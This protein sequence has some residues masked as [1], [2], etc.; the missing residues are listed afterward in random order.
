MNLVSQYGVYMGIEKEDQEAA[1]TLQRMPVTYQDQE[2]ALEGLHDYAKAIKDTVFI[3]IDETNEVLTKGTRW[4]GKNFFYAQDA[5]GMPV[6]SL[7]EHNNAGE[8]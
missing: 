6:A 1:Y 4:D 7:F 5:E 2:T 3:L 8:V